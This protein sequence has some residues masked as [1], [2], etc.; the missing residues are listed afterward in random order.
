MRNNKKIIGRLEKKNF[1]EENNFKIFDKSHGLEHIKISDRI[2]IK[3][4]KG[5][6]LTQTESTNSFNMTECR[7]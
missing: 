4:I 1:K 3:R 7:G 6:F 2:I 5:T